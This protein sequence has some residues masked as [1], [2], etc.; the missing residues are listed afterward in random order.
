MLLTEGSVF[1]LVVRTSAGQQIMQKTY[2]AAR[3]QF[4]VRMSLAPGA[5]SVVSYERPCE[6]GAPYAASW[7]D[8]THRQV[9][10]RARWR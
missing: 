9:G 8:L 1:Y 10:V 7:A 6:G 3:M 4:V 5:Y 2:G